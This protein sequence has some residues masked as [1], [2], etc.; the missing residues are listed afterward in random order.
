METN[1]LTQLPSMVSRLSNHEIFQLLQPLLNELMERSQNQYDS[2][3]DR[4]EAYLT[5]PYFQFSPS[6]FELC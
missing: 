2:E 4:N 5:V 6:R 3:K 1:L